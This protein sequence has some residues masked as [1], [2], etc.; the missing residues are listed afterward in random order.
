MSMSFQSVYQKQLFQLTNL[1]IRESQM[2]QPK[3]APGLTQTAA[4]LHVDGVSVLVKSFLV[5]TQ[6]VK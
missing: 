3:F 5:T 6:L 1:A 2:S 4:S